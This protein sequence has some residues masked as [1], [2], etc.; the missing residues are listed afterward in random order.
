MAKELRP[1]NPDRRKGKASQHD[2][3]VPERRHG[4]RGHPGRSAAGTGAQIRH[5]RRRRRPTRSPIQIGA[6]GAGGEAVAAARGRAVRRVRAVVRAV[7][8]HRADVRG[9]RK[10]PE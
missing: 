8:H 9:A 4:S 2:R 7:A 6:G 3:P 5:R 10:W 1:A